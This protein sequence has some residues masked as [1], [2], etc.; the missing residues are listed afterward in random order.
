MVSIARTDSQYTEWINDICLRFEQK[1]ISAAYKV[2]AELLRFYWELGREISIREEENTYGKSFFKKLSSDLS[3][4]I[5]DVKSFS[6]T[7]LHYMKWFYELY[8]NAENL[9]QAGVNSSIAQANDSEYMIFCI[10]FLISFD[11]NNKSLVFVLVK[12]LK[13][14]DDL[15]S[16]LCLAH[17]RRLKCHVRKTRC[18]YLAS[19]TVELILHESS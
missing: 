6:I 8:P 2:N 1:Q 14:A 18:A 9:P 19:C 17:A 10:P 11:A 13:K 3:K 12:H 5:P 7:N 4:R 15:I 16:G